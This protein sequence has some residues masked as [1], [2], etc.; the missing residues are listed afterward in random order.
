VIA[1]LL[2]VYFESPN[3]ILLQGFDTLLSTYGALDNISI[4]TLAPEKI[5]TE[6][7]IKE[8]RKRSV[9]VSLGHSMADLMAGERAVQNGASLITHLFNAMLPVI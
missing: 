4:I 7:V 3:F 1:T 6:E 9:T 2:V 8:L 5:K